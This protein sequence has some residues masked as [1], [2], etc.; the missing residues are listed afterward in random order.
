MSDSRH[1]PVRVPR[2]GPGVRLPRPRRGR[3]SPGAGT[4]CRSALVSS[5]ETT[6]AMSWHRSAALRRRKVVTVKSRATRIDPAP[7]PRVHVAIGGR[8]AQPAGAGSA[9]GRPLLSAGRLSP[10]PASA[11]GSWCRPPG[12]MGA[13]PSPPGKFRRDQAQQARAPAWP[14]PREWLRR[15]HESSDPHPCSRVSLAP[16]AASVPGARSALKVT[17]RGL[18][19]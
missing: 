16:H 5:S 3:V 15:S 4:A 12:A 14:H 2:D 10:R 9:G 6:I 1:E 11:T 17:S 7:A 19:R 8:Q 18:R 13:L